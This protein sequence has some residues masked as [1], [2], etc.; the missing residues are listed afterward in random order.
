MNKT[1]VL[2][3]HHGNGK[4]SE[5]YLQQDGRFTGQARAAADSDPDLIGR[6]AAIVDV[7]RAMGEANRHAHPEGCDHKCGQWQS[8]PAKP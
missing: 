3:K 6:T 2:M 7:E 1:L 4:V 5:V 8:V